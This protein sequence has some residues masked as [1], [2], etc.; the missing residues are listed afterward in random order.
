[1]MLYSPLAI[2]KEIL[3]FIAL[4]DGDIVMTGTPSG[5]GEVIA[6]DH[7][8]GKVLSAGKTLISKEWRAE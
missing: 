2:L 6:G 8:Q 5:V 7:F 1:M 3:S 4:E